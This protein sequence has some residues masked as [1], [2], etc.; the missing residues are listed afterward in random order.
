MLLGVEGGEHYGLVVDFGGVLVDGGGGLG[1]E[2]AVAR[3][4]IERGDVVSAVRAG[5]LHA[6]FDASDS[7][8]AFHKF[9][10]SLLRVD[11]KAR[12]VGSE[13]N[14]GVE[15]GVPLWE[16]G[17]VVG[18][19]CEAVGGTSVQGVLRLRLSFRL[20]AKDNPR[21]G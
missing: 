9:E 6:A 16:S 1:A 13:G 4:E 15:W 19:P 10:C 2:V 20:G 17:F 8:E 14:E 12:G 11:G 3:V 18:T 5:E 7:V 21:S